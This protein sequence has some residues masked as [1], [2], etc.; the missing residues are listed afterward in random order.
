MS[1]WRSP[2]VRSVAVSDCG[3]S[4]NGTVVPCVG[5]QG[6]IKEVDQEELWVVQGDMLSSGTFGYTQGE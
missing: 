4:S 6:W 2:H 5:D 3:L 1:R